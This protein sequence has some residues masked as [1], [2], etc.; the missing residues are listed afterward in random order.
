METGL[1]GNNIVDKF[2]CLFCTKFR[3]SSVTMEDCA[4]SS[5]LGASCNGV[6]APLW[7]LRV[8]T[9]DSPD[10][11]TWR[12]YTPSHTRT[13]LQVGLVT[14]SSLGSPDTRTLVISSIYIEW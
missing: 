5:D 11:T 6:Q 12:T 4:K 9:M 1:G 2:P 8:K 10:S 13:H 7:G 14:T 3:R